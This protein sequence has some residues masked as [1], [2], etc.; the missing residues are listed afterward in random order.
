MSG[1]AAT[2]VRTNIIKFHRHGNKVIRKKQTGRPS[3]IPDELQQQLVSPETLNQMRFLPIRV[4]ARKHSIQ[5][6]TSITHTQLKLIYKRHGVRFRQPKVSAR[7]PADKEVA[8][9]PERILFAEKMK[10]LIDGG[11]VIIYADES[12]F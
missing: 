3:A 11:R 1:V 8:L 7:L 2:T 6:G 4:R 12:T 9:I 10:L 5:H